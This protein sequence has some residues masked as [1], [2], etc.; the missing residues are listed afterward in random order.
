MGC[1]RNLQEVASSVLQVATLFH[2]C[3]RNHQ[4]CGAV[5]SVSLFSRRC[6]PFLNLGRCSISVIKRRFVQLPGRFHFQG[7]VQFG[8]P[9]RLNGVKQGFDSETVHVET[10]RGTAEEA[11]AFCAKE[12]SSVAGTFEEYGVIQHQGQRNDII[13]LKRSIEDSLIELAFSSAQ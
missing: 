10:S 8:V 1:V 5:I 3:N 6:L 2:F 9:H 12:D 13:S 11:R 4:A 7:Y